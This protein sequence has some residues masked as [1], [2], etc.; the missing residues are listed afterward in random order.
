MGKNDMNGQKC[1]VFYIIKFFVPDLMCF[2]YSDLIFFL[3]E[4]ICL[5]FYLGLK[6]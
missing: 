5:S 2:V 4:N 3:I 6:S 1:N